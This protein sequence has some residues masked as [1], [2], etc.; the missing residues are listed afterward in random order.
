MEDAFDG[1][2]IVCPKS[3]APYAAMEE[4]TALYGDGDQAGI[5]ALEQRLLA[6]NAE[7]KDWA[8]TEAMMARTAGGRAL[9]MHPL[10]AD[11]TGES[12]AEGEVDTSVFDRYR[13]PL[14]K[15]AS[16]KPYAIAAMIFLQKVKDPAAKLEEL[17]EREQPRRQS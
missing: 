8:C 10:P 13:D 3:W 11:I 14:Y 12:C 17:W 16:N 6:Q 2:D 7:H 5:A 15:Q 1:A 4:R 9:Y